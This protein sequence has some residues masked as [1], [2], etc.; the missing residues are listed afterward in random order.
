M[1]RS[2]DGLTGIA[3]LIGAAGPGRSG[4]GYPRLLLAAP[5]GRSGKTVLALGILRAYRRQ[6]LR[7][8][9][10]K[11][12]PDFIDPGWH[13]LAAGRKSRN[14]DSFFMDDGQLT[15][16][17]RASAGDAD[18]SII[19]GAMG[20]FDGVGAQGAGSSA[21]VA[22]LLRTPVVLVLDVT[23]MT[24]TAAALVMGCQ[25]FDPELKIAGVILNRVGRGRRHRQTLKESIETCCHIPVV[26]A[27]PVD[28][29]LEIPDRHLGLISSTE[30]A[31]G[32]AALESMADIIADYVDLAAL[33]ALAGAGAPLAAA[34]APGLS[35]SCAAARPPRPAAPARRP[36]V[37]VVR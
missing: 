6:N 27:V 18:I 5:S 17:L 23:R 24:R 10:F 35:C 33:R 13:S 22:K 34:A 3:G 25:H 8:Q 26:G 37:A 28:A 21:E 2:G 32:E 29:R 4:P 36:L 20:L 11:K 14:L 15:A 7:V 1:S 19:E 31:R 9:P 16:V 12:G 30:G